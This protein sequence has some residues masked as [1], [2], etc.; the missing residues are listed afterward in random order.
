MLPSGPDALLAARLVEAAMQAGPAGLVFVA[1]GEARALR[2]HRA[3]LALAPAA[4]E[5]LL[6]PGWDVPPYDRA[7]PSRA[8]HGQRMAT[9]AAL[10]RD[11]SG[12]CLLLLP[13][14]A[15][16]QRLG[17][18]AEDLVLSVGA[19]LDAEGLEA[20]L[21]DLGYRFD[22]RVDE[23]GEAAIHGSTLDLYP[24]WA[25]EEAA[26]RIR[27]EDGRIAGIDRYDPLTQRSL[28]QAIPELRLGPAREDPAQGTAPLA[29]LPQ[30]GIV[31]DQGVEEAL[32]QR[33][34]EVAEGFAARIAQ[35]EAPP[36]DQLYLD[37]PAW[38]A[39]L[40]GREVLRVGGVADDAVP[41]R[42]AGKPRPEQAFLRWAETQ[43]RD[44]R[45]LALAGGEE[46]V[47]RRL[48]ARLGQDPAAA[49][50]PD[51]PALLATPPGTLAWWPAA[52]DERGLLAPEAAV[53]PLPAIRADLPGSASGPAPGPGAVQGVLPDAQE[54][55]GPGDAVI[56]LDHG[57]AELCG[58]E[59]VASGE[60]R[61]DCLRLRFAGDSFRLVPFEDLPRI[62][63]YGAEAGAVA[64]DRL[65][66]SSWVKR[67]AEA[68]A[69]LRRSAEALLEQMRAREAAKAPVL[70]AP[71][72]ADA[73]VAARFRHEPT[74][75]QAAAIAA[76]LADLASGRPMDRLVCG[77]VGFGKTEVA[78]RAAA[79]AALA[80]RQV[81]L[82]APT[83]VLV[84]QHL[85]TFRRRFAGLPVRIEALSRLS[86]PAEAR[87][88]RAAIAAGEVAIAIGTQALAA[89]SVRF[90]DL[91]LLI[92]DE[93]QRFGA[94]EKASLARLRGAP[95]NPPWSGCATSASSPRRRRA[96]SPCARCGRRRRI[97]C[98]R[99][100]CGGRRRGA[101]SPSWSARA[102]RI[103][104]PCGSV[105]NAWSGTSP[106]SR[107]MAG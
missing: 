67:R 90:R 51:W 58:V 26:W 40:E 99:A 27:H 21:Q 94:R 28:D 52:P 13:A 87:A 77:D 88:T 50:P 65:D 55:L 48:L 45:R 20:A 92:I 23:P 97:R 56:H 44:G 39:G 34:A 49:A 68:E 59:T 78:I 8:V 74:P 91:G 107:R 79:A 57:L 95:C 84:R 1:R 22:E 100:P 7:G 60:A 101:G 36:P 83:T 61:Q 80:G 12:P 73:A 35:A 64:L 70:R 11:R 9:A 75:G 46:R 98:W 14:E 82:L 71:E 43:L 19:E 69:A 6:L 2:L 106:W 38:A 3:A 41:P 96:A 89:K 103:S 63:R 66:G 85:E 10:M 31:L 30:A 72:E 86:P 25:V 33:R 29:L 47:P 62:W 15:A 37:E 32:R 16:M 5:V 76:T 54:D 93:E 4:L 18:P 24:A 53:I 81:A 17:Q 102:S 42:F 105:W 104:R